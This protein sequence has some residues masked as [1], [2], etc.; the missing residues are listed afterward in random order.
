MKT[1]KLFI[2]AALG[3]LA[4]ASCAREEI[5]VPAGGT[6]NG[7]T[8][9]LTLSFDNTKTAL[10]G[11]KTTWTGGEVVR[12]YN[13]TATFYQDVT[14]P[15]SEAGKASAQIEVNM[16]DSSYYAVYPAT[17]AKAC[18]PG[19]VTVNIPSNPDGLFASANICAGHSEGNA[20]KLRNV[21]AVLKVNINSG[22]V[23][24]ILQVNAKNAMVGDCEVDL[25]GTDPV[26]TVKTG[27]KSATVAIGGIDGDY[28]IP[29]APGTYAEEFAVT[30]LRGN[31]GFQTLKST[32]AND[33]AINTIYP[34]GTIGNDLSR[35][36]AGE[37]T[38][39]SPYVISNLGEWGAFVVSVNLGNPYAGKYVKLDTDI[40]DGATTPIGYYLADDDQAYFAGIFQGNNH[41]VKLDIQGENCK[42]Q[43]YCALFGR[44]DK[45]AS[46]SNLNV[47]GTVTAK[48]DYAAGIIGYARGEEKDTVR[49]SNCKSEVVVATQGDNVGGVAAYASFAVVDGCSNTGNITGNNTV[50]GVVGYAFHS[51]VKAG[52]NGGV[53]KATEDGP[54]AMYY[55]GGNRYAIDASNSSS[56]FNNGVGG[57]VGYAQNTNLYNCSNTGNVTAYMKVG[58]VLGQGYWSTVSNATNSGN[59]E[60]TG[61]LSI[62]ADSQAGFQWG[63][64]AGGIIGWINTY[65]YVIDCN[66]TGNVTAKGGN[67]G[68]VGHITTQNNS[69]S[70]PKIINCVN[71][72]RIVSDGA[73]SGGTAY[74]ANAAVGGIVGSEY[75]FKTYVPT[76]TKCVNKGEVSTTT[77]SAGGILGLAY[78]GQS[79]RG[80]TPTIDQCVNEAPVSGKF[81]VGGILGASASRYTSMLTSVVNCANYGKVLATGNAP[82]KRLS[83][84][85][86]GGIVGVTTAY[87]LNYRSDRQIRIANCYNDGDVLYSDSTT[88]KPRVGGII[89]TS[90]G[91]GEIWNN[92][93]A[94]FVGL[95]TKEKPSDD[96]IKYLGGIAGQQ[97]ADNIKFCYSSASILEGQVL[98][99]ATGD[100]E[101]NAIAAANTVVTYDSEGTLSMPVTVNKIDC[102]ILLQALNEWQN[103]HV[104]DA[105]T[106]KYCNWTGAAGHPVFDTTQD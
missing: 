103:E 95:E 57:V 106:Y 12:I 30:A 52:T 14:V 84:C 74:A 18:A 91:G 56:T 25:S 79:V 31:G 17:A 100:S 82:D 55:H 104:K 75:I 68:I 87:N 105:N 80:G 67:G 40:E 85:G 62:K 3:I 101:I 66:N 73:Y 19:K 26:V 27:T 1:I 64:V 96:A 77:H 88:G 2:V 22:N 70:N 86:A 54:T 28:Y 50:A 63:S 53:I 11:G 38:E 43:N 48:G 37:G 21:T 20:L 23:I 65:A 81:W 45:G 8:S 58:G 83:G 69:A 49:I 7:E 102:T 61:Q 29:V 97:D 41:S 32:Q 78:Q 39:A 16:A 60:G 6:A 93:N 47:S 90:W 34:L 44:L 5:V 10:V 89:G 33:I 36:L 94:G 13:H 35:G 98:G 9:V 24:E 42:S 15:E 76:I 92:Y 51:V 4:A 72:G 71:V 46:I 59:V 99:T